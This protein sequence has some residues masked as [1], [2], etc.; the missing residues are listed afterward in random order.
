[1]QLDSNHPENVE[2]NGCPQCT[3]KEKLIDLLT[4]KVDALVLN[5]ASLERKVEELMLE[6]L[7]SNQKILH[8]TAEAK[9]SN[10]EAAI[11]FSR[12]KE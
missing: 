5:K 9:R 2:L 1:M 8:L 6:K 10:M 7:A 3:Q 4:N 11:Y 12:H